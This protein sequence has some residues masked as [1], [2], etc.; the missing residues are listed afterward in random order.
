MFYL[1]GIWWGLN[2][3]APITC[4]K[5][6]RDETVFLCFSWWTP[7]DPSDLFQYK[8]VR[9]TLHLSS[10]V[11]YDVFP[12]EHRALILS[13]VY[14][15]SC[16]LNWQTMSHSPFAALPCSHPCPRP[17][18]YSISPS[19][20]QPDFQSQSNKKI[21]KNHKLS[22]SRLTFWTRRHRFCR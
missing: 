17:H 12:R 1:E 3:L 9:Q 5:N 15:Y 7:S 11:K 16:T 4:L 6:G 2:V 8:M 20:S 14:V 10:S 18:D 22:F 13:W 19:Q 21:S